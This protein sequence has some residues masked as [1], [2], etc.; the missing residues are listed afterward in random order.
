MKIGKGYIAL[1]LA[2]WGIIWLTRSA[3]EDI[4]LDIGIM[5]RTSGLILENLEF[6]REISGDLWRLRTPL[7]ERHDEKIEMLSPDILRK[8]EN[9]EEWHFMGERGVYREKEES[10]SLSSLLGTLAT[11]TRVLNLRSPYLSWSKDEKTFL[12]PNGITVY[13]TEF[14]LEADMASIDESGI[15]LLDRGGVITWTKKK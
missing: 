10:A 11:G 3:L 13:D 15:I 9:G 7:A 12:F 5:P 8:L 2:L 1:G 6:E 14:L 4:R